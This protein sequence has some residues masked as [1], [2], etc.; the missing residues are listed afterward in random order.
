MN[1]ALSL[2]TEASL[3]MRCSVPFVRSSLGPTGTGT[4]RRRSSI[5]N[6][7]LPPELSDTRAQGYRLCFFGLSAFSSLL[8][9][10]INELN[11]VFRASV[12]E[13]ISSQIPNLVCSEV[14]R[15]EAD[16]CV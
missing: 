13:L 16:C 4:A 14:V 7:P 1:A 8:L 10:W 11:S 6:L 15:G 5:F 2:L 12:P 3:A 9:K